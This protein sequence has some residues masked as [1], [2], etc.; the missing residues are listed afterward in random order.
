MANRIEKVAVFGLDCATPQLMFDRWRDDL[1]N[2]NRLMRSGT[3]G[4]LKSCIPPITVPAWSCMAASKDPGTLGI[5]GF[6]NRKDY[7]Y[8][9]LFIASSAAVGHPRIWDLL[10]QNGKKSIV[11]GLPG[12]YPIMRPV[13]GC[14]ITG[15]LAPD[16]EKSD[17]TW[18]HTLKHEIKEL[19]GE[20]LVDVPQFRTDDKQRLLDQIYEMTEKRFRV[21]EHLIEHQAWD[22]LWLVEIGLDRIHHGFWAFM[23]PQ[24]HRYEPGNP[25][26]NAIHDYWVFCDQWVGRLLE[27]LDLDTTA[28]WVV[29]DHGAQCMVG[30]FCINTWLMQE[31]YLHLK[32]PPAPGQR[33]T[34]D[35]VDWSKT[36]A[37]GEGGYYGRVFFNVQG[38]EPQGI[39]PQADFEQVRREIQTKLEALVDHK[40]QPMGTRAYLPQD[41]YREV[42][43]VPP[44]LVVIFGGLRWRSVGSLGHQSIYTFEN[45]TGP[46]DANHAQHGVYVMTH[47]SLEAKG[48]VD[49]PTLYDVTP[50]ILK[51]LGL[52]IPADL[53][54]QPLM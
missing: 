22:L 30:G 28:V 33:F 47:P 42:H 43:R 48:R 2:I 19:V 49:G 17:Y 10:G 36:K 25:L 38:R 46:D 50:T 40:G 53:Q 52:P 34:T 41:L 51:Q 4:T 21:V 16:T 37:W 12:T 14:M 23:D 45:D 6:R 1:P 20:Y 31:G 5:Y 11:V 32:E 44:D 39:I 54:G 9:Q 7:S 13:N 35:L 8:D 18:P 3:Y 27:K 26:E 15:F 24:H 29:S